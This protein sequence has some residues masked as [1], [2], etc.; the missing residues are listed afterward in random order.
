MSN[1]IVRPAE[2]ED[3]AA[4][5]GLLQELI[6]AV[7][8]EEFF[9]ID[10]AMQNC[11]AMVDDA[12]SY[13]IVAE[14]RN[15]VVGFINFTT[16]KTLVHRG[17]SGLIDELVV[18]KTH[19]GRGVGHR[20]VEAAVSRCREL[21]CSEIEVSTETSNMNARRFYVSCGFKEDAVLLELHFDATD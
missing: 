11:G 19:R 21:G 12:T 9:D 20:L 8:D 10:Y 13:I 15:A 7:Q 14:E 18:A 6:E 3:F 1:T 5:K 16:R 2:R 4:I 17:P